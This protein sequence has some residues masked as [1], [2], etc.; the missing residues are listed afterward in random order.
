[1]S[2]SGGLRKISDIRIG[3]RFRKDLGDTAAFAKSI[4]KIDLLHPVVVTPTNHLIAGHRRLAAYQHAGRDEIPVT[5]RD[6]DDILRAQLAENSE[7]KGLLPSEIF[8]V[9]RALHRE[10]QTAAKQRQAAAGPSKGK[11]KKSGAGKLPEAACGQTRDKIGA[12]AGVSGKTVEKIVAVCEA[13]EEEPEKYGQLVADMDRTGKAHGACKRLKVMRQAEAILREPPPLP[14][15]GPYRVIIADVPW[16][17]GSD[18]YYHE[19]A[20]P[21][22]EMS[23]ADICALPV[24][25]IAHRNSILFKWTTN[26]FLR[27]AF[28][29]IDAWGFEY[30]TTLTWAKD[31]HNALGNWLWGQTE[32]CL[33]A[34]RGKPTIDID[35]HSTLLH[36]ASRAHSEKPESFYAFVESYAPA[37]R[38]AELFSRTARPNWDGH[39][40]EVKP[41]NDEDADEDEAV[42]ADAREV[43]ES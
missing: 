12:L 2:T 26:R 15:R 35:N 1:M 20:S 11:G 3:P 18:P 43:G 19:G 13:A 4:Q 7:R 42:M 24:G 34:T 38:Y 41:H 27:E 28:Q 37:P 8:E 6:V 17:Y 16:P 21:Y 9:Y 40:D 22:P 33:V 14:G 31:R 36:G 30:R 32:H 5:V 23:I 25:D 39:G 29:V 10:E